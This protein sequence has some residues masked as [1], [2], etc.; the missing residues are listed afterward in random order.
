MNNHSRFSLRLICATLTIALLLPILSGCANQSTPSQT[1]PFPSAAPSATL[2]PSPTAA[3]SPSSTFP[4]TENATLN[5]RPGNTPGTKY[6]YRVFDFHQVKSGLLTI[7]I[8]DNLIGPIDPQELADQV[9]SR[10]DSYLKIPGAN[11][12]TSHSNGAF[13]AVRWGV[14]FHGQSRVCNPRRPGFPVVW[15]GL[16]GRHNRHQPILDPLRLGFP[17]FR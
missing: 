15:G 16:D 3:P 6:C 7:V 4:S 5:L 10:F 12:P 17:R 13:N 14:L 11:Q 8:A 2:P 9:I 1:E